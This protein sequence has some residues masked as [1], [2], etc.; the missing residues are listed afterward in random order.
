[1]CPSE[2][3]PFLQGS[4]PRQTGAATDGGTGG[5]QSM[6]T[7]RRRCHAEGA[8]TRWAAKSRGFARCGSTPCSGDVPRRTG[9]GRAGRHIHRAGTRRRSNRPASGRP[10]EPGRRT[11]TVRRAAVEGPVRSPDAAST[12]DHYRAGT[13]GRATASTGPAFGPLAGALTGRLGRV[14]SA[15]GPEMLRWRIERY[16]S[17]SV[18]DGPPAAVRRPFWRP[19]A[20]GAPDRFSGPI[21]HAHP[22]SS[23][24]GARGRRIRRPGRCSEYRSDE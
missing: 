14:S 13:A 11:N 1:M 21:E 19:A 18:T 4:F 24:P 22:E 17:I 5:R 7:G 12:A 2:R 10:V 15:M 16:L 9:R 3:H 23:G 6:C 20:D 8:P